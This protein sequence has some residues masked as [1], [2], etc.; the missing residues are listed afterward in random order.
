MSWLP[1]A[2]TYFP[3]YKNIT[4]GARVTGIQ[5]TN[6]G[7]VTLTAVG[8]NGRIEATF[9]KVILAIPPAALKMIADLPRWGIPKEMA[10]RSIHFEAL[11]KIGLRFKT[12]F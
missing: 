2:V 1:S 7:K 10:I 3:G 4:Y 9:D 12:R 11:Y 6:G 5:N 8:F